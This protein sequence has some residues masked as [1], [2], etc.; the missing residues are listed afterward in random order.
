M[1][2]EELDK[3]LAAIEQRLTRIESRFAPPPAQAPRPAAP[4]PPPGAAR[5]A[6]PQPQPAAEESP[7]LVTSILG[8]GGAVA[9]VLAA[10]YLIRLGI[11]SGWLT[12]MRQV[13]LAAI[14]GLVLIGAGFWLSA[15]DRQYAGL[16]PAV[17]IAILF[18]ATYG[19]HLYYGFIDATIA[20]AAV[21]AICLAS[22]WLCRAFRSDLY[23]L[24][25][26]AGSYS[27]PFLL[28]SLRGSIT[29]LVVY[30]SAWS[31]VFSVYAI[32]HGRR[33]IYLLALY[34]A[35]IGFDLIWRNR[36]PLEW[37][38]ALA[39]QTAQFVIFGIA[40]ALYSIRRG[41]P[42]DGNTA[43]GHLPPL[44]LFY[45]LQYTLLARHLPAAAPW[46][47]VGSAAALGLLYGIARAALKRPLPGG[48]FLLWSY[49]ALV[50][51]H[52]GYVESVPKH[53]APWVAFLLVPIAGV[54]SARRLSAAAW[55][56]WF[57]VAIIFLVNYLRVILD[58]DLQGVAA[59]PALA[60][61]YAIEL[62]A[63]YW[64]VRGKQ[65]FPALLALYA[66]HISAMAA[67][68]HLLDTRIVESTAWAL[69]ALA[70]LGIAWAQRD[71]LLGQSSLLLF[72]ATAAKV[73]LYD[74][75]G[76]P[77]V[78]RII[79]LVVLGVAFYAGGLLYQ[80]IDRAAAQS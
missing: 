54:V 73:M 13:A 56:L 19:A 62:Y 68:L 72:G 70:C 57:A 1:I 31:V 49:V 18:L 30:F 23:A 35:L 16:L 26:V 53:W 15:L 78:A 44:L 75:S 11:D 65:E 37:V 42:L 69:L 21:I 4:K 9:L 5:P 55:P 77:P 45:F 43:L 59:R 66:G 80:R 67:A 46:I 51:F 3:R 34:L 79:S 25:A 52:A 39:F 24:F 8:W 60:V 63:A 36:A 71:R 2:P 47:A 40:T 64:L 41:E 33:L 14:A 27:A 20:A 38:P 10:A 48:E 32:W 76:A 17:G 7:S 12:P 74:L 6:A 22:L 58:T 50:L 61:A 28:S 29:D